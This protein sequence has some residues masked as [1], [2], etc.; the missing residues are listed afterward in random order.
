MPAKAS[1]RGMQNY[2]TREEMDAADE[3]DLYLMGG[4][5]AVVTWEVSCRSD[6]IPMTYGDRDAHCLIDT[7]Y[8]DTGYIRSP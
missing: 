7:C 2:E 3:N 8:L 1:S 4:T 5:T 6:S